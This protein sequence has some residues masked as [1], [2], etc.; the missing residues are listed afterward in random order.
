MAKKRTIKNKVSGNKKPTKALAPK[1]KRPVFSESHT[2]KE[3]YEHAQLAYKTKHEK[4]AH[5]SLQK[6][7]KLDPIHP[8]SL[9]LQSV[10]FYKYAKTTKQRNHAISLMQAACYQ[11][12]ERKDWFYLLARWLTENGQMIPALS[13]VERA[14]ML[15][16]K[17]SKTLM[18]LSGFYGTLGFEEQSLHYTRKALKA[19]PVMTSVCTKDKYMR[20]AVLMTATSDLLKLD[21]KSFSTKIQ[22]GHNNLASFL[23]KS[24]ITIKRVFVDN[25][26]HDQGLVKQVEDVDVVYNAITDPERCEDALEKAHKI[27]DNLQLPLIN[28]PI[29]VLSASREGNYERFKDTP[30]IILPKSVKIEGVKGTARPYIKKAMKDGG[31]EY[32][33]VVRVSGY[34]NGKFMHLVEDI[35]SHDLTDINTLTDKEPQTLYLIQ[36]EDVGIKMSRAPDFP[37]YPKYRAF[38]IKDRLYP[39]HVRY[40]YGAWNVHM[41]ESAP[42]YKKFPWLYD[43]ARDYLEDPLSHF[44]EQQ[45]SRLTE[46]MSTL[47]MDYV[48]VDFA[49]S[50]VPGNEDKIVIFE[51]NAAMRSFLADTAAYVPEHEAAKR[52]I[53]A[54]HELFTQKGGVG[55]WD[56]DIPKGKASAGDEWANNDGD[57]SSISIEVLGDKFDSGFGDWLWHACYAHLVKADIT[58]SNGAVSNAVL[59]GQDIALDSLLKTANAAWGKKAYTFN[60]STWQGDLP[61]SVSFS[62]DD[63]Q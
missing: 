5:E 7:L 26:E 18:L 6:A 48:G 23:D 30:D 50:T 54:A 28:T 3:L 2:V 24:H 55:S 29:S 22:E 20:V 45:W 15:D 35:D 61:K 57:T 60:T 38:F 42:T 36:F 19:S 44:T 1:L 46:A 14:V 32:P 59:S 10:L 11:N 52:A 12:N 17:D 25:Y 63:E 9:A 21:A 49:L 40:G 27:C 13:A 31:F 47:G 62:F 41:P 8:E 56:F 33:V 58:L 34:Q 37:L 53:M 43:L 39:V 51:A 4:M 16:Q